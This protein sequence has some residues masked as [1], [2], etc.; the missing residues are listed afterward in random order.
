MDRGFAH[1]RALADVRLAG[2]RVLDEEEY[3]ALVALRRVQLV[4]GRK[5][6]TPSSAAGMRTFTFDTSVR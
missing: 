2:L 4:G 5:R 1:L 3:S 6:L